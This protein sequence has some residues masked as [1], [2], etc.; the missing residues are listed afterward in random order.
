MRRTQDSG[1]DPRIGRGVPEPQRRSLRGSCAHGIP[2]IFRAGRIRRNIGGEF[3]M[4]RIWKRIGIGVLI[5]F[6]VLFTVAGVLVGF[7]HIT[8]PKPLKSVTGPFSQMDLSGLPP[9]TRYKARDGAALSYRL[10]E[11]KDAQVAVLIHGSAGM[12]PFGRCDGWMTRPG[13]SSPAS[14]AGRRRPSR[15]KRRESSR[16]KASRSRLSCRR[17]MRPTARLAWAAWGC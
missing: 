13:R 10:Y 9:M 5:Y 17:P 6:V 4:T 2:C 16:R 14:P 7:G 1:Q 11:G 8:Q 15:A 12:I 3:K